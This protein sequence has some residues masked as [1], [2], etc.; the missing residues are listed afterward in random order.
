MRADATCRGLQV[1]RAVVAEVV[2]S[3]SIVALKVTGFSKVSGDTVVTPQ[4]TS[5][6]QILAK[7][8]AIH[9]VMQ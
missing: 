8:R 6:N 2:T 9:T 4:T 7:R 1:M 5:R 3:P